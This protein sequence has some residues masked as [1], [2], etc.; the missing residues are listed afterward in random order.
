MKGGLNLFAYANNNPINFTDPFGFQ[1]Y[2]GP[3]SSVPGGPWTWAPDSGNSRGGTFRDPSGQAA[4]WDTKGNHWDVDNGQGTRQRYNR[5]GKP[6]T[7]QQAHSYKGPKQ[8]PL[9]NLGKIMKLGGLVGVMCELLNP[10]EAGAGSDDLSG[11]P[12]A[13]QQGTPSIPP[14]SQP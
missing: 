7:P 9:K 11:Q 4:S 12:G 14:I 1:P 8:S 5:W 10:D 13:S 6:L 3:P 2:P